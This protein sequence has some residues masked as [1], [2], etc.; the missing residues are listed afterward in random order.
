M[1]GFLL[2][3]LH[4]PQTHQKDNINLSSNS[5]YKTK[6]TN[7]G[8]G[9]RKNQS[10]KAIINNSNSKIDD[11]AKEKSE[12]IEFSTISEALKG[13]SGL[14]TGIEVSRRRTRTRRSTHTHLRTHIC[15]RAHAHPHTQ[16]TTTQ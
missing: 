13:L 10:R 11:S 5:L 9:D 4:V 8:S 14:F 12:R 16:Q 7:N 15:T 1:K 2:T 6:S 3:Q